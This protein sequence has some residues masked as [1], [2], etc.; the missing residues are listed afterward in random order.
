MSKY[1]ELDEKMAR[2]AHEANSMRDYRPNQKT[3]EYRLMVDGAAATAAEQIAL[4]PEFAD[5]INDILDRYSRK[6]AGWFNEMSRV[7]AMCPSILESGGSNFPVTKKEK[8]NARRDAMW[9][10]WEEIKRMLYRMKTIGTGG[11]KASDEKAVYKLQVA[12]D[13]ARELQEHMKAVNAYY[14]KH[15]TLDG[16]EIVTDDE[17][18]SIEDFFARYPNVKNLKPYETY[19]FTNNN[20]KI[21]RLEDR[22]K[23]IQTIK[24]AGSSE[25][26]AAEYEGLKVVENTEAMRIQLIFDGKPD[27][28]V[29]DILKSNG[30]RWAPSQG[31]WQRQLNRNGKSAAETVLRQLA[32][33]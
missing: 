23:E 2:A 16:C 32:A 28:E 13:A 30:F 29:R 7:D 21:H 31:A 6:L 5:E 10:K 1:Y 9:K 22:I 33:L 12:L 25:T 11:I 20:A 15:K 18:R 17:R 8:Q 14:R 4:R 19:E 3:D 26:E 27:P 24:D